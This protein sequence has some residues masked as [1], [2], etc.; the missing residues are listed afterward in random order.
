VEA[1]SAAVDEVRNGFLVSD[2]SPL[3]SGVDDESGVEVEQEQIVKQKR[4]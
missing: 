2:G 4:A 1:L 3:V